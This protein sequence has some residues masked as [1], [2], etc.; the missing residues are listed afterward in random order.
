MTLVWPGLAVAMVLSAG[1][2]IDSNFLARPLAG[3]EAGVAGSLL[4]IE[5]LPDLG[6]ELVGVNRAVKS[7]QAPGAMVTG[8]P[9]AGGAIENCEFDGVIEPITRLA[10]PMLQTCSVLEPVVPTQVS[11]KATLA[12]VVI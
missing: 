5:K 9:T 8:N 7:K 6:P 3:T 1:Q 12:G 2:V 11:A 10:Q 4:A